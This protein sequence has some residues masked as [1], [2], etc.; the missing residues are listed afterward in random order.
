MQKAEQD[1]TQSPGSVANVKTR[2]KPRPWASSQSMQVLTKK[3]DHDQSSRT[4]MH[5]RPLIATTPASRQ[6]AN[7]VQVPCA[8]RTRWRCAR[9]DD[10]L[11]DQLQ[12]DRRASLEQD[13][14]AVA[15]PAR[16]FA[17][18]GGGVGEAADARRRPS[19][20]L[21]GVGHHAWPAGRRRPAGQARIV[22]ANSPISR[23]YRSL[24]LPSSSMSPS[25][26]IRRPARRRRCAIVSS[27]ARIEL[28]LALYASFSTVTPP[29]SVELQAACPGRARSPG[30]SM[31]VFFVHAHPPR[32]P[33]SRP[34]R[35]TRCVGRASA[36]RLRVRLLFSMNRMPFSSQP[37]VGGE[38]VVAS[39]RSRR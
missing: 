5:D 39:V 31:I 12:M 6:D 14:V 21:G 18:G 20:S 25:T 3:V 23:W 10:R 22:A 16:D 26:A 29:S 27:A 19:R 36:R 8:C 35:C 28:G 33:R 30:R 24:D 7:L 1:A 2:R 37:D 13:Q 17:G 4:L 9:F 34:A 15:Q 11:G 32:R 38:Q